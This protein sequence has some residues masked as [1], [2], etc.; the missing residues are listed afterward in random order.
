MTKKIIS[1][2]LLFLSFHPLG[3]ANEEYREKMKKDE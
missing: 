3:S 1:I 2:V